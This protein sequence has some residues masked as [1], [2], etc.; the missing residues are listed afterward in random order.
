MFR[1]SGAALNAM[2]VGGGR[3]RLK[4]GVGDAAVVF[5]ADASV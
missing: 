4:R 1:T 2:L 3:N 5:W